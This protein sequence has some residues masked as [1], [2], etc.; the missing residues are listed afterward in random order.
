V[1]LFVTYHYFMRTLCLYNSMNCTCIY[2]LYYYDL[3]HILLSSRQLT[4]AWNVIKIDVCMYVYIYSRL[5]NLLIAIHKLF[6]ESIDVYKWPRH[7][8]NKFVLGLSS[9]VYQIRGPVLYFFWV[10][11]C[12]LVGGY[13]HCKGTYYLLH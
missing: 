9:Q 8:S 11:T 5:F 1:D 13:Q 3:F 10:M 2:V 7:F 6:Y 12:S 4:D